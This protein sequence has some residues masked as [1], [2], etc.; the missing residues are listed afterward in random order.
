MPGKYNGDKVTKWLGRKAGH[1]RGKVQKSAVAKV[2]GAALLRG[3][4]ARSRQDLAI[5]SLRSGAR[6]ARFLYRKAA[7]DYPR[8][9]SALKDK[10]TLTVGGGKK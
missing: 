7:S 1:S 2:E 10:R 9:G 3:G 4:I 5:R 6:T 8:P